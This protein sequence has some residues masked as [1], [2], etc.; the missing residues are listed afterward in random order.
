MNVHNIMEDVVSLEVG[1]LYDELKKNKIAWL[2]CD[3]ESCRLDSVSYVLNHV[4]PKYVVSGRGVNHS[5]DVLNDHQLRADIEAIAL[6][7]IRIV[8]GAKRPFHTQNHV[9]VEASNCP[10]YNFPIISGVVLDGSNFEPIIDATVCI[11]YK[12]KILESIDNS[13]QNPVVTCK[14]TKGTFNFWIKSFPAERTGILEKFIFTVEVS[15]EGYSSSSV[16]VEVPVT[17]ED[18]SRTELNSTYSIK[19]KDIVLFK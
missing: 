6:E 4:P 16:N 10:S 9:K 17:S 2:T 8:S 13:W 12:G 19:L 11:K 5:A 3:C 15:A 7:G 14:S 18:T 1:K